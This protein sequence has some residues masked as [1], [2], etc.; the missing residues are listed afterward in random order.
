MTKSGARTDQFDFGALCSESAEYAAKSLRTER[1]RPGKYPVLIGSAELCQLF[2]DVLKHLDS[3]SKYYNT[4]FIERGAEF[5]P[6]YSGA[7]FKLWLDPEMNHA[8]G[9]HGFDDYGDPQKKLLLVDNNRVGAH[10]TSKKIADFLSLP[11]TT[12][13]GVAVVDPSQSLPEHQL[14]RAEPLVL[15][16]LQFS[17][18]FS[19]SAD[20]TFSSEIRLTRLHD[21]KSGTVTYIKG[22][23]ISGNFKESFARARWSDKRKLE[24]VAEMYGA[25]SYYGPSLALL[26]DVNVTA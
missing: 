26:M 17:A 8:F 4:P 24:N 14:R 15:E 12:S 20:L 19:N 5:I 21:A 7:P 2:N 10:A 23:S 25:Q 11:K 18:L 13:C 16:I 1:P 9:S 6:G 3:S 22:G